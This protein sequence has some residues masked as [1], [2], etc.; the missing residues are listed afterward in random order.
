MNQ[1][2]SHLVQIQIQRGNSRLFL[3]TKCNAAML[4]GDLG[5]YEIARVAQENVVF[6]GNRRNGFQ[7]DQQTLVA[8]RR[9]A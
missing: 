8:E 7:H 5:I 3:Y 9:P 2:V 4:F 1:L 6:M